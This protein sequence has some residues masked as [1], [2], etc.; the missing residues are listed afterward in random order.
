MN[1]LDLPRFFPV[2][3]GE[4]PDARVGPVGD[5]WQHVEKIL[6]HVDAVALAGFKNR[7]D[8]GYLYP[9]FGTSYVQPVLAEAKGSVRAYV[10]EWLDLVAWGTKDAGKWLEAFASNMQG[11]FIM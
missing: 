4:F 3:R 11:R 6:P 8:G 9:G 7:G 10:Q 5:F 2:Q 1:R